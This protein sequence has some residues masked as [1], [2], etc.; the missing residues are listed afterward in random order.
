MMVLDVNTIHEGRDGDHTLTS[1]GALSLILFKHVR[2]ESRQC[3]YQVMHISGNHR[4]FEA[5]YLRSSK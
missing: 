5:G 4:S 2:I 3:V 1:L